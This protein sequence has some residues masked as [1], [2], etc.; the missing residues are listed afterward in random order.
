MFDFCRDNM[1]VRPSAGVERSLQG[2]VVRLAPATREY[3]LIR[4]TVEQSGHLG[5]RLFHHLAGGR[6]GPM[7]AGRIPEPAV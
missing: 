3:H 7:W 2:K 5:M 4:R 1:A 6:S